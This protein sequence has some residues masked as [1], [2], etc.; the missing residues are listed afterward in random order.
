MSLTM[1]LA[2]VAWGLLVVGYGLRRRLR[3]H[4]TLMLSGILLDVSLVLYLEMTRGA[5]EKALSFELSFF[6]QLHVVFSAAALALYLPTVVLGA[7][8]LRGRGSPLRSVHIRIAT[9]AL[10]LRTIGWGLMFSMWR[11]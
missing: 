2:T 8:L 9:T 1:W 3:L 11:R 7:A 5:V 10:C 4:V 6:K